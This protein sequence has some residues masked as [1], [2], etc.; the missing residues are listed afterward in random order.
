MTIAVLDLLAA[1]L[2]LVGSLLCLTAA[3]GLARFPDLVSR[4]HPA[5]KPQSLGMMVL[6]AGLALHIRTPSAVL[7][8]SLVTILQMMTVTLSSHV[9]ART[10]YRSGLV[11]PSTLVAD[12]LAEAIAVRRRAGVQR[13]ADERA[14]VE[15]PAARQEQAGPAGPEDHRSAA[16]A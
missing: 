10:G 11:D 14:A 4:L 13:G 8:L 1:V 2:C 6:M 9:V 12:E 16:E 15:R 3:V 7:L 5:A